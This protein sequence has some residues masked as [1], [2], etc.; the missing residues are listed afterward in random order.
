M[1]VYVTTIALMG[2]FAW[3]GYVALDQI[4][5]G[6]AT[7]TLAGGQPPSGDWAR[8]SSAIQAFACFAGFGIIGW[9]LVRWQN[10]WSRKHADEEFRLK[11]FE[12][13]IERASWVVEMAMEW[14]GEKG[15]EIPDFLVER[16]SAG[17]FGAGGEPAGKKP[18]DAVA[19]MIRAASK[20][21]IKL[22]DSAEVELDPKSIRRLEKEP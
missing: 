9:F 14:K 10:E 7:A 18:V 20:A 19:S 4:A 2:A 16:L 22:G 8:A 5:V 21:K 6:R 3:R 15:E 13:D 17:L 1:P 11:Q 12:L